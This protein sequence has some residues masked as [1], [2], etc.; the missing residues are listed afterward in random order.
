MKQ[1]LLVIFILLLLPVSVAFA[2]DDTLIT[3][4][5]GTCTATIPE[6]TVWYP[7]TREP[8]REPLQGGIYPVSEMAFEQGLGWLHIQADE[9]TA[10]EGS[11]WVDVN[12]WQITLDPSCLVN[13]GLGAR[14][15]LSG[16]PPTV[17]TI[18]IR[19]P[20]GACVV[21]EVPANALARTSPEEEA[22][23]QLGRDEYI[24]F[25][26]ARYQ[27]NDYIGLYG[28][29]AGEA[30]YLNAADFAVDDG[31]N[32]LRLTPSCLLV[33]ALIEASQ[34]QED[35]A[36]AVSGSVT[37]LQRSALPDNAEITIE[38]VDISITD[39]PAQVISS[40]TFNSEGRQVPFTFELPYDPAAIRENRTYAVQASI[41]VEGRVLFRN[42]TAIQVL[43]NDSPTENIEI[44]VD[45]VG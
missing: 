40:I 26:I 41:T 21:R 5:S 19:Y 42:T 39:A 24:V 35:M 45:P 1:Y 23:L 22:S 30:I 2:Q 43:T 8:A 9:A 36:A 13:S 16:D 29:T 14:E 28:E 12:F 7:S 15:P 17:P 34:P 31:T 37:Y 18:V 6:G 32:H 4:E 20:Y 25:E 11:V 10:N 27:E 44:I 38:L 33:P 3:F